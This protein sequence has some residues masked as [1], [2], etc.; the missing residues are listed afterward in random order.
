MEWSVCKS[1]DAI[2]ALI[3][4][5]GMTVDFALSGDPDWP[6]R[7]VISGATVAHQHFMRLLDIYDLKQGCKDPPKG[8]NA[9][10]RQILAE[11]FALAT[12]GWAQILSRLADDTTADLPEVSLNLTTFLATLDMPMAWIV[13][14]IS[15]AGERSAVR[16]I[17]KEFE[18]TGKV[19]RNLPQ[20]S[21]VV[22]RERARDLKRD[23][24]SPAKR[25]KTIAPRVIPS[26][27]S[28]SEHAGPASSI[29]TER[30]TS[31]PPHLSSSTKSEALP[32]ASGSRVNYGSDLVDAPSIGPKTARRFAAIGVTT[33]GQFVAA[34]AQE[35]AQQLDTRWITADLLVDWQAQARLVC[36]VP[37][38]CG[39]KAQLLV[40]AECRS[41]SELAAAESS[42][43]SQKLQQVSQTSEGQRILRSSPVPTNE[44]V[45]EWITSA[46]ATARAA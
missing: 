37:A 12:N 44:D 43:L 24:E 18:A 11:L 2:Y 5:T 15:D 8:L 41:A 28:A 20:E 35:L 21:R 45:A 42:E 29:G 36:A 34:D 9:E 14:K 26:S 17:L 30:G 27:D 40:Q 38:L 13:R 23:S 1:Y 7:A 46:R 6:R 33:I 25:I 22:A 39:Y 19:R 32:A 16:K 4:E 31:P 3:S 10:A